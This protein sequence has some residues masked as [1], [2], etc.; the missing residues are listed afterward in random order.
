M[1]NGL[2][3]VGLWVVSADDAAD[4][5]EEAF[6]GDDV[7]VGAFLWLRP[8]RGWCILQIKRATAL[9]RRLF[10]LNLKEQQPSAFKVGG[11]CCCA[12]LARRTSFMPS[13]FTAR[14]L[15]FYTFAPA[16]EQ[17]AYAHQ[18]G[19]YLAYVRQQ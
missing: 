7:G 14:R 12:F 15:L 16:F 9:T 19:H 1:S 3:S 2:G 5:A 4:G 8:G 17:G 13:T 6:V 10:P 18:C 11:Y